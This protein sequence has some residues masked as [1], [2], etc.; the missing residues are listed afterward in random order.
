MIDGALVFPEGM[1]GKIEAS[2][3]RRPW[4]PWTLSLSST[5]VFWPSGP[6]RHVPIGWYAVCEL[7]RIQVRI[8]S[9]DCTD[10]P[11]ENSSSR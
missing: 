2:A 6:M 7:L 3:T 10:G 4:M 5:T 1:V 9:S 8:S 11:G